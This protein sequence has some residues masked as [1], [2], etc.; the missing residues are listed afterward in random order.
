MPIE[1]AP[2]RIGTKSFIGL[3]AFWGGVLWLSFGE[4]TPGAW[5][6]LSAGL[7]FLLISQTIQIRL[8]PLEWPLGIIVLAAFF[9]LLVTASFNIT[10]VQASRLITSLIALYVLIFWIE[11]EWRLKVVAAAFM[12]LGV[13]LAVSAPFI[14][15][16]Q[17]NKGGLIPE[18]VYQAMPDLLLADVV[19]PNILATLL[20]LL[21]PLWVAYFLVGLSAKGQPVPKWWWLVLLGCLLIGF[22]FLLTK[23]R[24]GYLALAVSCLLLLWWAGWRKVSL[25]GAGGVGVVLLWVVTAVDLNQAEVVQ[26]IASTDTLAFRQSVWRIALWMMT[27]FPFTGVGMGTFNEVAV[28]LY[29]FPVVDDPGAHNL[30]FQVGTDLGLLGLTAF[31]A[32]VIL[33]VVMGVRSLKNFSANDKNSRWAMAAG[34]TAG[35]I[36]YL[37]HGLVDN[38]VWGT[39]MTF[40]PWLIIG[41]I[42]ALYMLPLAKE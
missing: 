1:N 2:W 13:V 6:L 25:I 22:V 27:D 23:S 37:V 24:G 9:S 38:T 4:A 12:L 41:F 35:F 10:L 8:T 11:D 34:T 5:L 16:W 15:N 40:M 30:F 31:L 17:L 32:V 14:V 3:A 7:V 26:D 42:T 18:A 33:T 21:L 20:I 39:R 29:P 36:G 28:R 19:H